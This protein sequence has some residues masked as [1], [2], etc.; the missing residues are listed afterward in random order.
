MTAAKMKHVN[1]PRRGRSRSNSKRHSSANGRNFDNS[2]GKA[3]VRGTAKQVLDK[4]LALARDAASAGNRV[5]SEGYLQHAEHYYRVLNAGP[6]G[7]EKNARNRRRNQDHNK[8]KPDQTEAVAKETP[9]DDKAKAVEAETKPEAKPE[10]KPEAE[11]EAEQE[12]EPETKD[13]AATD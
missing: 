11:P 3:K 4:Y 9:S 1:N 13:K 10:T 7:N 12:L 6:S 2:G 8:P 5:A